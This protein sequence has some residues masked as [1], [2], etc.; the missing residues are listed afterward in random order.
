MGGVFPSKEPF[1]NEEYLI[2]GANLSRCRF[3][4]RRQTSQNNF[5]D[6]LWSQKRTSYLLRLCDKKVNAKVNQKRKTKGGWNLKVETDF[7]LLLVIIFGRFYS[8]PKPPRLLVW[9]VFSILLSPMQSIV[10]SVKPF[11]K[12]NSAGW[13][14]FQ[15][16]SFFNH[17]LNHTPYHVK[18]RFPFN[19]VIFRKL[20]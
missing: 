13:T 2:L 19:T 6:S 7:F 11:R 9:R 10:S 20:L 17:W 12:L 1:S 4:C 18:K 5:S 15:N 3:S 14:G 8:S 16:V